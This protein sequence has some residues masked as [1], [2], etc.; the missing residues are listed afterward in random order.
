MGAI[1]F[2]TVQS[3]RTAEEAFRKAQQEAEREYG[4]DLYNG[5]IST[6]VSFDPVGICRDIR[7]LPQTVDR[8]LERDRRQEFRRFEKW[9]CCAVLM[10]TGPEAE[11]RCCPGEKLWCFF[12]WAAC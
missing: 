4:Q 2:S 10:V 5:T 8:L 11:N 12:G 7:K 1:Q 3:A 9:G 6:V